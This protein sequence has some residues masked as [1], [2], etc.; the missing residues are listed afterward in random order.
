[1]SDRPQV[2]V[3]SGPNGSGKSTAAAHLIPDS[4]EYVNADE[5]AKTLDAYPSR[6]ADITAGRLVLSRLDDLQRTRSDFAV[7]T[8]LAGLSLAAR[9][10]SLRDSG[11][12]F[13]LIFLWTPSAEFS[14]ARVRARV[15]AGGHDIPEDTIRRR[16]VAGQV[17]FFR[18]YRGIA[19]KWEVYNSTMLLP[20]LV[21]EGTMSLTMTVADDQ[22]W[23][24]M[25][26]GG[27]DA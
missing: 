13:R 2:I 8:T 14:I 16:Y 15:R 1:M 12:L 27:G 22:I 3:M 26:E 7:E 20:T 18:R 11:Y 19:D 24:R 23:T 6:E 21:A 17:N 5:I 4:I 25:R 10:A 9:V